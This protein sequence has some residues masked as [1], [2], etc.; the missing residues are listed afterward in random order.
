MELFGVRL[1]GLNAVTGHKVLLTIA[2][3]AVL[4][5]ARSIATALL[6]K[7]DASG[8]RASRVAFWMRQAV[9]LVVAACG[10]IGFVS[11]WFDDPA[12]LTTAIGLVSAGLAFA[13]QKVITALA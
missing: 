12:H 1:V 3:I 10:V 7:V 2:L 9:S 13:L 6:G 4:W 5:L 8:D 11:I